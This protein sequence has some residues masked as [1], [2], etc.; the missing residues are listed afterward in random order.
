MDLRRLVMHL[1]FLVLLQEQVLLK[2]IKLSPKIVF[3]LLYL[4]PVRFEVRDLHLLQLL[5][6]IDTG[7][8]LVELG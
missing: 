6:F 4:L 3:L 2:L 8:L 1:L 5:F 7:D